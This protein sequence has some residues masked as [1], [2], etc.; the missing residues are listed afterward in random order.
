MTLSA[1]DPIRNLAQI[2]PE[3]SETLPSGDRTW[4][5]ALDAHGGAVLTWTA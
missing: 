3:G 4:T 1:R 5:L 2:E